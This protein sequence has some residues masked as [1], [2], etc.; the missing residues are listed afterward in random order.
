MR[1]IQKGERIFILAISLAAL[2]FW[3]GAD[4]IDLPDRGE[5]FHKQAILAAKDGNLDKAIEL[6]EQ[7]WAERGIKRSAARKY[8]INLCRAYMNRSLKTGGGSDIARGVKYF[9]EA[10]KICDANPE[11]VVVEDDD[12]IDIAGMFEKVLYEA[13][14]GNVNAMAAV[15]I[16]YAEGDGVVQDSRESEKWSQKAA[17]QGNALAM[18]TLGQEKLK[19]Y[20][21]TK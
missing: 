14:H 6:W 11:M 2:P 20:K 1:G 21:Q 17:E 10:K 7:A 19:I 8:S 3:C 12:P 16:L 9:I 4:N 13:K 18:R 15:G 5:A